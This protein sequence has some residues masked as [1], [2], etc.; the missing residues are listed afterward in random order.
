ML[1]NWKRRARLLLKASLGTYI[2]ILAFLLLSDAGQV[3]IGEGP[4]PLPDHIPQL[5]DQDDADPQTGP[6]EIINAEPD[7]PIPPAPGPIT[8]PGGAEEQAAP[9]A[10]LIEEIGKYRAASAVCWD[11]GPRVY[12]PWPAESV[13]EL[14]E[15]PRLTRAAEMHGEYLIAHEAECVDAHRC[16]GEPD[17]AGRLELV[18]YAPL[19]TAAENISRGRAVAAEVV[20]E[21][22]AKSEKGHRENM[23]KCQVNEVGVFHV[24]REGTPLRWYAVAVVGARWMQ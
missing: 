24:E 23:L 5:G 4:S 15:E 21:G 12:I 10:A 14:A 18:G 22:W 19:M 3:W 1:S 16:P 7:D 11:S 2:L 9:G 6:A 8:E 17:F 20:W 13:R